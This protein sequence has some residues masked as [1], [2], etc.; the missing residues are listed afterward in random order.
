MKDMCKEKAEVKLE[1]E[2][3]L[4][5]KNGDVSLISTE[6]AVEEEKLK[7]EHEDEEEVKEAPQLNDS[8]FSK[9]DELL[10][11]THLYTKFLLEKMDD[12]TAVC[13]MYSLKQF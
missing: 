8:Q 12:I 6:M 10:T 3:F 7:K 9:L 5:A 13:L 1:E 4:D 11:Q 2:V